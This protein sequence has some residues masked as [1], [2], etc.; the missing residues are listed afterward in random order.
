[1]T[2]RVI[3]LSVQN[4]SGGFAIARL[5]AEK[6][7]FRYY[8]WEITLQAADLAGVPP[9]DVVASERVPGFLERMMRRLG[10]ISAMSIEGSPGLSD[11]S[12]AGWNTALQSLSSEDYRKFIEQV[13]KRLG[14]AGE[15]VIVG[16]AGQHILRDIPGVLKV[17]IHG[18]VDMRSKRHAAEQ[19]I[20]M[21]QAKAAIKQSDKERQTLLKNVYHFE[22]TD[23]SLYDLTLNTDLMAEPLA[24]GTIVAAAKAMP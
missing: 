7:G 18:S 11:P 6:L 14:E 2:A 5:V 21:D 16:H 10:S 15:A 23:A 22:W 20:S 3:A 13:I 9:S 12:P 4:G 8:D 19:G 24:V 1:M 17:F